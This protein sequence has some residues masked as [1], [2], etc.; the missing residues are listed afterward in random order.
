MLQS[1]E[2]ETFIQNLD[3]RFWRGLNSNMCISDLTEKMG[4]KKTSSNEGL[5]GKPFFIAPVL[6]C[7]YS[8]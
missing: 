4:T 5:G 2:S 8:I 3:T 6:S 1:K 7:C